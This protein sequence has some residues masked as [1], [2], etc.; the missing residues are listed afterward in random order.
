MSIR[1][2]GIRDE[3]RE[4]QAQLAAERAERE[5][6]PPGGDPEVERYRLIVRALREPVAPGLPEDFAA[7]VAAQAE[8]AASRPGFEARL[9]G[10]LMWVLLIVGV[11]FAGRLCVEALQ[12]VAAWF[13]EIPAMRIL[14]F[15][16]LCIGAAWALDLGWSARRAMHHG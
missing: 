9:T 5:H 2:D 8:A 15:A 13:V 14:V 16:G 1:D 3:A 7:R 12:V 11:L 10:V 6:L 4:R